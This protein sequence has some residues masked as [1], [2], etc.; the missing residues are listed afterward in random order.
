MIEIE[1]EKFEVWNKELNNI[2]KAIKKQL[3]NSKYENFKNEEIVWLEKR[4]EVAENSA[5]EFEGTDFFKVQ[6]N[7]VLTKLTKER[8][9]K[10]VNEYLQ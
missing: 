10:L 7:I 2:Y 8:C 1:E 4:N 6:Y 9:Y 5:K 3:N